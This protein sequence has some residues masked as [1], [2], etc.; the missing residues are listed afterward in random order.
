MKEDELVGKSVKDYRLN[1]ED[2]L[3][4]LILEDGTEIKPNLSKG[5]EI[6][7]DTK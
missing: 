2:Q 5:G 6:Y 3:V 7:L 4:C 1:E